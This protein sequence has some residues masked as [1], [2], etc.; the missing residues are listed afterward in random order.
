RRFL[1][2]GPRL[3]PCGVGHQDA[4]AADAGRDDLPA[5]DAIQDVANRHTGL[6]PDAVG[7]RVAKEPEPADEEHPQHRERGHGDPLAPQA[8]W[9][10][11][12]AKETFH[13]FL[14]PSP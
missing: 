11:K 1:L 8:R 3:P 4:L 2:D 7:P 5:I 10:R 6:V 13:L 9:D 14:N 12:T